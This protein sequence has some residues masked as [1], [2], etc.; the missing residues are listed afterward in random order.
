[1]RHYRIFTFIFALSSCL[2]VMGQKIPE[3]KKVLSR[4]LPILRAGVSFN[5]VQGTD[6]TDT[7]VLPL[8]D[9]SLGY[10]WMINERKCR[11][12]FSPEIGFGT[13]G[14][15]EGEQN[16][17]S[18]HASIRAHTIRLVPAQVS[19]Q[20][21]VGDD[22]YLDFHAGGF[23]SYDYAGRYTWFQGLFQK[24]G[25][26]KLRDRQDYNRGDA[27]IQVG[28][29]VWFYDFNVDFTFRHGFVDM[30]SGKD[31]LSNNFV[32]HVG[33]AFHRR[34]KNLPPGMGRSSR[35]YY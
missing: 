27:G 16:E 2:F 14:E 20:P 17:W 10:Q 22:V 33:Y 25:S 15:K 26:I 11:I 21:K 29:G 31:G 12:F 5:T 30:I 35:W 18:E 13:R 32:L 1:M 6:A 19:F 8:Y 4:N 23:V 24:D 28:T 34:P 9:V 3:K 7:R